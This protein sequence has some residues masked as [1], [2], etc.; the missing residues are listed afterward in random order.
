MIEVCRVGKKFQSST[1]GVTAALRDMSLTVDDG[2][3]VCLVGPSGCG[4]TTLLNLIAGLERPDEGEVRVHGKRV[5]APGPDRGVMFQEA[6]LFPWLS[7]VENVMF[8]MKELRLARREREAR[9]KKY[10]DLVKMSGFARSWVHELSGGMRQRVALA[11]ALALEP[12]ML[13]MDEPFGAL[14]PKSRDAL[15]AE[16]VDIWGKTRK[17]IVFV[18]HDMAEAVRLGSRVI[19][20]R[21]RPARVALDVNVASML[22]QPRHVDQ[23]EVVELA[24]QLKG[25]LDETGDHEAI[26]GDG[27]GHDERPAA[28]A[29]GGGGAGGLA[30]RLG[31]HF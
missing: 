31:L 28:T 23:P 1:R 4:K 13:L 30:H 10:L 25:E 6:A 20:L 8:G 21:A 12:D 16:I 5:R 11:R 19:V 2:E 3:F 7:V 29:S 26:D 18:T 17:T 22:P 14:D 9:A 27:D 15:Q 24:A